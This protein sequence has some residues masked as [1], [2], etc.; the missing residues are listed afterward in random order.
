MYFL[1][2]NVNV[3]TRYLNNLLIQGDLTNKS[4]FL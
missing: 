3:N 4:S 2:N 1:N